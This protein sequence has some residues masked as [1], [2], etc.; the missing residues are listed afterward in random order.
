VQLGQH[1]RAVPGHP[2]QGHDRDHEH[3]REQDDPEAQQHGGRPP[4]TDQLHATPADGQAVEGEHD[5]QDERGDL[6]A[7]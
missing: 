5:E 4:V 6:F 1:P 7:H 3:Q 2:Q